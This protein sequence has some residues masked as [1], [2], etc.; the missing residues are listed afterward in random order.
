MGW[1]FFKML[2]TRLTCHLVNKL[3]VYIDNEI[4]P[5]SKAELLMCAE[6]NDAPDC[7]LDTIESIPNLCYTN[8]HE[9]ENHL[10]KIA[11]AI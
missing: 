6:D 11:Q 10:S 9:L 1:R 7:I 8:I 4:F 3:D 2:F 5:C